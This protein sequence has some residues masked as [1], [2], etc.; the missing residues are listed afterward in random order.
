MKSPTMEGLRESGSSASSTGVIGAIHISN[1]C[2]DLTDKVHQLPCVIKYN[3][4]CPVSDYFK[5]KITGVVVD[6]LESKE[7]S[8]RGRKLEGAT[9]SI[10]ENYCGFV[11]EKMKTEELLF[12]SQK[13]IVDLSSKR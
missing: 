8:F 9:L 12:L 6:E 1:G 13:I 10:P 2:M 4:P 3:G 7:A 11:L 5:P